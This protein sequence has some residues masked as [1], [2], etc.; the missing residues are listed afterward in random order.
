MKINAPW[1][2][3]N[4]MPKNPTLD[5]RMKWHIEHSKNFLCRPV[6]IKLQQ[7]IDKQK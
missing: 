3:A 4:K 1:H 6:P 2:L 5:E 7:V